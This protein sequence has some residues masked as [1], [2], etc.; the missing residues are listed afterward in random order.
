MDVRRLTG[1]EARRIAVRAQLLDAARPTELVPTVDRLTMLQLDPTAVVAP[2]ADLVAWTRLGEGYR[3]EDLARAVEVDRALYEHSGQPSPREPGIVMLRPMG[4]LALYLDEMRS[5]PPEGSRGHAWLAANAGFRERVLARLR[6][7][8]PLPS[9]E[10]EDTREVPWQSTGWTNDKNVTRM[11]DVLMTR[12]E[13]AVSA[14]RGRERLWDLAERV[15]PRGVEAVP[16]EEAQ[17]IRAER[18]LRSLGL[19]RPKVV[20]DAGV[21]AEVEG[22]KGLWRLDPDATAETFEGRTALLSPFDRLVHDRTRALELFGFEYT[23]EMYK[24]KEQRR[25]GYFALPVLSGDRL[26]GKVDA[27]A[28][29]KAGRLVVHAVHRDVAWTRKVAAAVDAELRALAAWLR[30]DGVTGP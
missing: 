1:D 19:A 23:L 8:G 27:A 14:R 24:P 16:A 10:I 7:D 21:P 17:R 29:R 6:D 4:D 11:L 9:R 3:P 5:W 28:D 15:Y 25:W 20:G 2:N 22:T 26:V 30:L 13:V 18:R 12:G